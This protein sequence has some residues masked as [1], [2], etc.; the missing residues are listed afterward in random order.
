[1]FLSTSLRYS[2]TA[3][4]TFLSSMITKNGRITIT[5]IRDI[6]IALLIAAIPAML[7]YGYFVFCTHAKRYDI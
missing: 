3:L 4:Y 7:L 2:L 6:G 1:M 5:T